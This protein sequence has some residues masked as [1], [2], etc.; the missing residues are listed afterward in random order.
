MSHLPKKPTILD[1]ADYLGISHSTVSRALNGKG[2]V[3]EE[4]RTRIQHEARRL[5]YKPNNAAI[6]LRSRA[7]RLIGFLASDFADG[8]IRQ[9]LTEIQQ[10]AL[11]CDY[12]ILTG[13]SARNPQ[14]EVDGLRFMV[15]RQV[16][17][18]ILQS[19]SPD[20]HRFQEELQRLLQENI[21]V[22]H[23]FDTISIPGVHSVLIDNQRAG[24]LAGRHLLE[25][26]HRR[27]LYLASDTPEA[28]RPR[29]CSPDRYAGLLQAY[30]EMGLPRPP[31]LIAD[32]PS[33]DPGYDAVNAALEA[34]REFTAIITGSE[35]AA[36]GAVTALRERGLSVPG[37]CSLVAF[38]DGPQAP[39][40][41]RPALTAVCLPHGEAGAA[42]ID[43]ILDQASGAVDDPDGS[44][45]A[46][47]VI[48][49]EPTLAVR[50]S[51]LPA[52]Q[53]E[54]A[55]PLPARRAMT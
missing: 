24:Y 21:I 35:H 4:T 46:G 22:V 17:G 5:G 41:I 37:H 7:S 42:A 20:S 45:P 3:S 29:R 49:L 44:I 55:Q 39:P 51:T 32:E 48:R 52:S 19:I 6:A 43:L 9:L 26:G 14:D 36:L 16:E 53:T 23:L 11:R 47:R 40:A 31:D 25:L 12:G 33:A 38:T 34:G 28:L 13:L 8:G 27:I 2:R 54:P 30:Q 50:D 15:S 10:Q 1:I 18:V